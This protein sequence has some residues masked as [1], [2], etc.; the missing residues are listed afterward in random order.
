MIGYSHKAYG[1]K[2]SC[3]SNVNSKGKIMGNQGKPKPTHM[4]RDLSR[5]A[6]NTISRPG[7]NPKIGSPSS[8]RASKNR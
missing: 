6:T 1:S 5:D 4:G 2:D 3:N 7:H 8:D